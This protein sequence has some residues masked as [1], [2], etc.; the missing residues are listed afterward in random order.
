MAKREYIQA[1]KDWL[2][3]K[4]KEEGAMGRDGAMLSAVLYTLASLALGLIAVIIGYQI[5]K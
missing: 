3:A 1:N 2:E 5:V 4:A